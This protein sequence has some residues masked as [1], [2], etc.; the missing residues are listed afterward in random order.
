MLEAWFKPSQSLDGCEGILEEYLQFVR[1][2]GR[3]PSQRA[4]DE[5]ERNL[6]AKFSRGG[7]GS[8]ANRELFFA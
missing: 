1:A 5:A 3:A 2:H 7:A 6:Y 8:L 4:E